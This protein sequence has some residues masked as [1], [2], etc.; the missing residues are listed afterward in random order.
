MNAVLWIR[1]KEV[2]FFPYGL[3]QLINGKGL[4]STLKPMRCKIMGYELMRSD[5]VSIYSGF[6]LSVFMRSVAVFAIQYMYRKVIASCARLMFS[7]K[8]RTLAIEIL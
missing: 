4:S 5:T 7:R 1:T 3:S 8:I 6:M 2:F